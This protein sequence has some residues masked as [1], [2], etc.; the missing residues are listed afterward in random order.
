MAEM[1]ARAAL[2]DHHHYRRLQSLVD[3]AVHLLDVEKQ[4]QE[5]PSRWPANLQGAR[6]GVLSEGCVWAVAWGAAVKVLRAKSAPPALRSA[7]A[8]F[9]GSHLG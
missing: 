8:V 7:E 4:C 9:V 2:A 1:Q 3:L 5:V 6:H